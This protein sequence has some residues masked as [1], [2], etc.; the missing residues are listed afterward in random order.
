MIK[1]EI[2]STIRSGGA[3]IAVKVQ[4]D[5]LNYL[6]TMVYIINISISVI[7]SSPK[8]LIVLV[9]GHPY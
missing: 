4:F 1:R 2:L 7:I 5:F 3:L 8:I 6:R 9:S